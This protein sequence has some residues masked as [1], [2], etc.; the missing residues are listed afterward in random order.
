M[1]QNKDNKEEK[2]YIKFIRTTIFVFSHKESKIPIDIVTMEGLTVEGYD[3]DAKYGIRIKHRDGFYREK[4]F[5][6]DSIAVKDNW[7]HHLQHF[8]DQSV[9]DKY[10]KLER[11][12]GGKFSN[13]FRGKDKIN[14]KFVAIKVI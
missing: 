3:R 1:M 13:V 2:V 10:I 12:G 11:I 9:F 7:L 5:M 4:V 6:F 8:K 14:D